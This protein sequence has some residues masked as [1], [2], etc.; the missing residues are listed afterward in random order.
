[1]RR[2]EQAGIERPENQ[3]RE[4]EAHSKQ[5]SPIARAGSLR[6]GDPAVEAELTCFPCLLPASRLPGPVQDHGDPLA[7]GSPIN[8]VLA[9]TLREASGLALYLIVPAQGGEIRSG[10]RPGIT[11]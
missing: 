1:M 7:P 9:L 6:G 8:G 2:A 11:A 3:S 4:P 10:D 5:S